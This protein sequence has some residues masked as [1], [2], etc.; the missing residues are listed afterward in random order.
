MVDFVFK[1]EKQP[2]TLE[3]LKEAVDVNDPISVAAYWVYSVMRLTEDYDSGMSM[4]KYLFADLEPFGQGFTEGGAAGRAGWDPYFNERLKDDDY[5]WLPRSYFVGATAANGFHPTEPLKVYLHYNEQASKALDDPSQT[6]LGR[7]GF[8]YY[9]ESNAAGNRVNLNI[10]RFGSFRR[11]YI[12]NAAASTG[13][14]YDQRAA[15]TAQAQ[16]KLYE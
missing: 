16:A 3:E 14:F 7:D 12:T 9:V 8:V 2:K 10:V 4:M 11:F 6:K 13:M 5:R 15:L 1:L